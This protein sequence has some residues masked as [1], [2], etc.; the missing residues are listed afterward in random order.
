MNSLREND[1]LYNLGTN[2]SLLIDSRGGDPVVYIVETGSV[3]EREALQRSPSVR[4]FTHTPG[5][6]LLMV[7]SNPP[8]RSRSIDWVPGEWSSVSDTNLSPRYC[9]PFQYY[10]IRYFR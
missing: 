2:I 6:P 5:N 4:P 3:E 8:C 7:C 10:L 1:C 9:I